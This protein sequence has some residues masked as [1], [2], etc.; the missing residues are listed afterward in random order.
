MSLTK[1]EHLKLGHCLQPK[2][3]A[4]CYPGKSA[5]HGRA[6]HGKV[7]RFL[8]EPPLLLFG[9]HS[10]AVLQKLNDSSRTSLT[11]RF[12]QSSSNKVRS[13]FDMSRISAFFHDSSGTTSIE[14]AMIASGIAV[15]ILGAV[16]NLGSVVKG[17]YTSVAGALK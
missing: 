6:K 12:V 7:G 13:R 16:T 9:R 4:S 17:N 15:V 14:Y 10:R 2:S 1:I 5:R 8:T 11:C 3:V